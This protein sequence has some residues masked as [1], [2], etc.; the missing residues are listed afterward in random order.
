MDSQSLTL[1]AL[2][3]TIA[4]EFGVYIVLKNVLW[5]DPEI[6]ML[7]R[8]HQRTKLR[9]RDTFQISP[10]TASKPAGGEKHTELTAFIQGE[11][12]Q[13]TGAY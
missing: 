2:K 10:Q 5:C 11:R 1:T 4:P 7:V 6:I 13:K 12:D 9:P 3:Y 8:S